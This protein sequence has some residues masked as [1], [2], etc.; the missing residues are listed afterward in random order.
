MMNLFLLSGY[1]LYL[2]LSWVELHLPVFPM[3]SLSR[4]N[5]SVSQSASEPT[6]TRYTRVSPANSRTVDL[7]SWW[8][9]FM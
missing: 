3:A 4:S 8:I 1:S 7:S 2:A 6:T 5:C 9:S